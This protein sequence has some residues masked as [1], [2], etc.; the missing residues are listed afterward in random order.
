MQ[1]VVLHHVT[2]VK[3]NLHLLEAELIISDRSVLVI[4]SAGTDIDS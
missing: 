1:D 3:A 4:T 2:F